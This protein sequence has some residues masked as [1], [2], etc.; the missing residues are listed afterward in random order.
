MRTM[1]MLLLRWLSRLAAPPVGS[2]EAMAEEMTALRAVLAAAAIQQGGEIRV[3]RGTL[4]RID[5]TRAALVVIPDPKT[6]DTIVRTVL[7]G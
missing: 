6:G 5:Q 1:K 4:E 2:P 3:L 7:E